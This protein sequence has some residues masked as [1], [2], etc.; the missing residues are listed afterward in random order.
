MNHFA[1]LFR[2]G[3]PKIGSAEYKRQKKNF[4]LTSYIFIN[5]VSQNDT[6]ILNLLT[7]ANCIIAK[8]RR[9]P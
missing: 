4:F 6:L 1:R 3:T 7:F 2:E 9:H 5:F 8:I